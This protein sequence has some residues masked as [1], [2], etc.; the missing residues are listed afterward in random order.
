MIKEQDLNIEVESIYNQYQRLFFNVCYKYAKQLDYDEK[1]ELIYYSIFKVLNKYGTDLNTEHM[2]NLIIKV[3][4]NE[5]I[6]LMRKKSNQSKSN[7]SIDE[8]IQ[9]PTLDANYSTVIMIEWVEEIKDLLTKKE[10]QYLMLIMKEPNI[11]KI[12]VIDI[13][14]EL[15]ISRKTFYLM[16]KRLKSKLLELYQKDI[17]AFS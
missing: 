9:I 5:C 17:N 8:E 13:C 4:K 3:L 6:Q 10:Y 15:N 11:E 16:K 1:K 2:K 12:S 7:I 14:K